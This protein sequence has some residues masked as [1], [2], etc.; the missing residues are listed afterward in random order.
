M[1]AARVVGDLGEQLQPQPL[2]MAEQSGVGE[3][4][5]REVQ[6]HLLDRHL[7]PAGEAFHVLRHER[8][9][10]LFAVEQRDADVA[11]GDHLLRQLPHD[12]AE[13]HREEGAADVAHDA[14]CVAEHAAELFG[15]LLCQCG[16]CERLPLD[17][18]VCGWADDKRREIRERLAVGES[19][20]GIVS[21]YRA[22]YGV[23]ALAVPPDEG[24]DR[25]TWALPTALSVL[26]I[27]AVVAVGRRL[28]RKGAAPVE[29]RPASAANDDLDARVDRE[30]AALED[31]E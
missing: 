29:A 20:E 22:L 12:L 13:L 24:L 23:K 18:C 30:L 26:A 27:F 3:L 8:R 5:H 31:D 17:T 2:R 11:A 21:S 25:V 14:S 4:A 9:L 1:D 15:R 19:A 16:A 6:P 28:K 7:E 10:A